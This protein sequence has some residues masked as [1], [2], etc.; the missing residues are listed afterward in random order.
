MLAACSDDDKD[1]NPTA[2][3][4]NDTTNPTDIA[5]VVPPNT[6][7]IYLIAQDDN[8]ASGEVIGCGDSIIP[9]TRE[10]NLPEE[11]T[12]RIGAA[13]ADL[14]SLHDQFYGESGLYNA[15]YQSTLAVDTVTIDPATGQATVNIT[16]QYLLGGACDNPR[17]QEQIQRT[18]RQFPDVAGVTILINGTPLDQIV[19]GQG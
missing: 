17:F 11:P 15:L 19:S 12:A 5:T 9:V 16:G 2:T 13:L 7:S 4:Q 10:V 6:Y 1:A 3:P 18:A 8:G 14:F